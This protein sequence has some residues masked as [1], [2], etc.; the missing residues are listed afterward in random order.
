MSGPAPAEL[1]GPEYFVGGSRSNYGDYAEVEEAIDIGFMPEVRRHA[2]R[3][4]SEGRAYLDVGCAY[5][6]YVERLAELGWEAA[7]VDISEYAVGRGR[8]R[9]VG[10]LQVAHA[11]ELPFTDASFDYVTAIDVIEHIPPADAARAV[12]EAWRVLRPGGVAFFATPNY[13]DNRAWNVNTPGFEDPDVTHINYQSVASLQ[14][15]F[16]RFSL[17]E[18]TGHTPFVDQFHTVDHSRPFG[19]PILRTW[20]VRPVARRVGWKLLGRSLAHSSYLH[21][22]AVK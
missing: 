21:A 15:L 7:G 8:A 5:G 22:V 14:E 20:P 17:C 2:R 18:V 13:L 3:V 12:A 19:K 11:Q 6:Y 10:N 4:R 9:G 16:S 1:Y